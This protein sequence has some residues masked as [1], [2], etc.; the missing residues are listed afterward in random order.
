MGSVCWLRE[1]LCSASWRGKVAV[2]CPRS[3]EALVLSVHSFRPSLVRQQEHF[4]RFLLQLKR[5][6]SKWTA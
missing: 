6:R 1:L 2:G 3:S 5:Y 4:F